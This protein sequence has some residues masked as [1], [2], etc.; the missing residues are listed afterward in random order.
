MATITV[1]QANYEETIKDG[2]VL[3]DFWAP[4]CGPCRQFGPIFE[5]VSEAYPDVVFAKVN[6]EE[7][8]ELAGAAQISAI[9]TLMAFRDGICVFQQAGALGASALKSLVEKV[10]SLDMD[11]VREALAEQEGSDGPSSGSGSF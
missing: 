7:E 10:Q 3:L 1:T 2:I 5:K 11:K 8:V 4:W 9:P 6:T